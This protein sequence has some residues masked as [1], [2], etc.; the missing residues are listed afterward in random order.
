[1]WFSNFTI[2]TYAWDAGTD[3]GITYGSSNQA[4]SPKDDIFQL[5]KES[6]P[7][8]NVFLSSDEL[9]VEPVARWSCSEKKEIIKEVTPE[10]IVRKVAGTTPVGTPIS[11]TCTFYSE[12][13][14]ATHPIDYPSNAHW[15]PMFMASHSKDYSIWD[16]GAKATAGVQSVA[17]VCM[18][19]ALYVKNVCNQVGI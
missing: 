6:L 5:T 9:T 2:E 14:A 11:Y 4:T 13:T 3:S 15:S 19:Y 8:S 18:L 16:S 1:M 10:V 12:W 17:E 7:S